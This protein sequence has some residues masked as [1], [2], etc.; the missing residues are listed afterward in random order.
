MSFGKFC[1]RILVPLCLP[2]SLFIGCS[3]IGLIAGSATSP[4]HPGRYTVRGGLDS[5]APGTDVNIVLYDRTSYQGKFAEVARIPPR[6][7]RRIYDTVTARSSL[8]RLIP[9]LGQTVTVYSTGGKDSGSFAGVSL[10]Q[11]L[12]RTMDG[13]DTVGVPLDDVAWILISDSLRLEGHLFLKHVHAGT[14]PG[15]YVVRLNPDQNVITVGYETVDIVEILPQS[16]GAL[17]G[18]LIGAAVDVTV[19]ILA[20]A[21]ENKAESDCNSQATACNKNSSDCGSSRR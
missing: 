4:S 20:V 14:I 10:G 1:T 7:Y 6:L 8:A 3:V 2:Y 21:A 11:V 13:L 5:L 15:M 9:R 16:S 17:T 18:F 19:I 12:V